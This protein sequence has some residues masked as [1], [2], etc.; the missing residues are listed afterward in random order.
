MCRQGGRGL[1]TIPLWKKSSKLT[2][3]FRSPEFF[4]KIDR[5]NLEFFTKRPPPSTNPGY[6]YVGGCRKQFC[7]LCYRL[8]N[9]TVTCS[10]LETNP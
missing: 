7:L 5:E 1:R 9:S 6:A 2:V 10:T 3:K 4:L 8:L